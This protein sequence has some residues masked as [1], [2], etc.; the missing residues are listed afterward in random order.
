MPIET[1]SRERIKKY[2]GKVIT[3]MGS[4]IIKDSN[5]E[6]LKED[7]F[8][9]IKYYARGL[10]KGDW[11]DDTILTFALGKS[12]V[13][14]GMN[15]DEI[16]KGQLR[17]YTSRVNQDGSYSGGFGGTTIEGF[18]RLLEGK[19]PWESGVIGGPGNAPPMKMAPLGLYAHANRNLENCLN[20]AE[21]IGRITHLDPR[22]VV[23]GVIQTQAIYNLLEDMDR[24]EFLD[25]II[26]TCKKYEKPLD[27][28][29]TWHKMGNILSRLEWIKDNEHASDEEAYE[30][31]GVSSA[32]YKSYPFAL[33]MF[34]K[35]WNNP[36]K[37]LIETV[38]YGGD[39]DTTGA[40]YGALAGANHGSWIFPKEW[41]D[42]LDKKEE[43]INLGD[44]LYCA[45]GKK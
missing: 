12:L 44:F 1:W 20:F 43:L 35:Y 5:G 24:E 10:K 11:T 17:E 34:Q 31:L 22:S 8:G 45:G 36:L 21:Q 30:K 3:P 4:I 29:F 28:R 2:I 32:V 25:S 26:E 40:M 14:Y 38:N 41:M 27:E 6:E 7:E 19:S 18:K 13:E 9:K 39:C 42:S 33:F 16:A 23:S 15:L 37:G